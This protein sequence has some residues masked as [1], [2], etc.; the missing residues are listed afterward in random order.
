[1]AAGIIGF[2]AGFVTAWIISA[3]CNAGRGNWDE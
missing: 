2:I 1:M 3:L